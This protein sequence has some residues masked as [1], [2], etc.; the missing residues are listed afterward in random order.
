MPLRMRLIVLV[1][2]V[3]IVSLACGGV[4]LGWH[5]AYS[6]RIELRA[7]L[8]V[9]VQTVH[10]GF[11][12]LTDDNN[13]TVG[14]RRLVA[15]F[16]GN[17]HVRVTLLD[18]GGLPHASSVLLVPSSPSPAWFRY[19]VGGN[20]PPVR[21]SVPRAVDDGDIIMLRADPTNE[22][23]EVWGEACDAMSILAGFAL[24]SASLVYALVGRALRLLES[25]SIAFGQIGQ[26]DYLGKVPERGPPELRSLA[27]GFNLMA[28]R[29]DASAM[30]NRRLNERL[31][32]LQAEERADLARDLHD[33]VGPLLF[34]VNVATATIDHLA[35]S[36]RCGDI[37]PHVRSV[38]DAVARSQRHVRAI[39]ERLRPL[40]TIGLVTAI[41]RLAAFWRNCRPE[42]RFDVTILLEE[43]R[44]EDDTKEAIYRVVQEGVSNAVRHGA[45]T[46]IE[47]VVEHG[48]NDDIRVE[49]TDD[50]IGMSASAAFGRGP[51]GFGLI[52]M[53]ERVMAMAGSLSIHHGR[54]RNGTAL[55]AYLPCT[56]SPQTHNPG[57]P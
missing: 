42:I 40:R 46:Q 7:A 54:N 21:L 20:L 28:Q 41:D 15:T 8:D 17:R 51:I 16:N 29:L 19:L 22:V 5:A 50:G 55:V 45:P 34:A 48:E 37:P 3:L 23:S 11:D 4:L 27:R 57:Q 9:G 43:D 30:Q 47:I 1:G 39:L 25:L 35:R 36:N 24:L 52:G 53:H 38:Y 32:T 12:D 13:R 10:N 6:V 33:E 49:V 31:L 18:A 44:V 14:L 2:I 56:A 26:G